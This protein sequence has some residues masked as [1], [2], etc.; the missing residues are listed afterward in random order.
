[1]TT[2]LL[3]VSDAKRIP[4]VDI[5]DLRKHLAAI[6]SNLSTIMIYL[7]RYR[8]NSDNKRLMEALQKLVSIKNVYMQKRLKHDYSLRNSTVCCGLISPRLSP[9][10]CRN[11]MFATFTCTN[12]HTG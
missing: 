8:P 1:M 6:M 3:Y 4:L 12:P 10:G 2:V 7:L 11:H 9:S 5:L